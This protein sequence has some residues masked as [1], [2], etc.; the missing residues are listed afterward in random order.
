[1]LYAG[2]GYNVKIYDIDPKQIETALSDIRQQLETLEKNH[3][4]RGKLTAAQQIAC[5]SGKQMHN[6]H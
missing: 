6:T 1:M 3:L 5:I 2:V 4:L